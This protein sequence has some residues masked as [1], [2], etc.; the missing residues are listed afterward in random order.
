MSACLPSSN[1]P[2]FGLPKA[3]P[4]VCGRHTNG[5]LDSHRVCIFQSCPLQACAYLYRFKHVLCIIAG[6]V[7]LKQPQY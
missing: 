5:L 2:I 1:V 7:R 3:M 6:P 4:P